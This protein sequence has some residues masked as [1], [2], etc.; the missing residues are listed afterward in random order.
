MNFYCQNIGVSFLFSVI[1]VFKNAY[2]ALAK[3]ENND[4]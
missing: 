1:V 3:T 4:C 2:I